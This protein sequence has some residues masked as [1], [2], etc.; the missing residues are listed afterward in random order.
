MAIRPSSATTTRHRNQKAPSWSLRAGSLAEQSPVRTLYPSDIT[1]W[2]YADKVTDVPSKTSVRYHNPDTKE[3][4]EQQAQAGDVASQDTVTAQDENKQHV[5]ARSAAQAKAIAEAEQQRREQ[6]KVAL[7]G[8]LPG[9][10]KIVA[11]AIIDIHG[12][13]RLNGLYLITQATHS[14]GRSGGYVTEFEAKRVK[15]GGDE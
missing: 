11:G 12:L 10:P 1:S 13:R 6:D 2:R 14:I 9:D 3:V 8:T 7:N 15:E 5:R 4:V